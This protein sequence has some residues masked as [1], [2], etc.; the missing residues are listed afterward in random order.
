MDQRVPKWWDK[1]VSPAGMLMLLGGIVWGIQL[2]VAVMQHTSELSAIHE[3]AQSS[4]AM[5]QEQNMQLTRIS[6]ILSTLVDD[7]DDVQDDNSSHEREAESWKRL[8]ESN[9][10]RLDYIE[11]RLSGGGFSPTGIVTRSEER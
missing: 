9:K 8:I 2:N 4:A 10:Q 3:R 7:V 11:K 1:F 6:L 5:N